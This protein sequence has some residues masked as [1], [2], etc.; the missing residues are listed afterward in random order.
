VAERVAEDRDVARGSEVEAARELCLRQLHKRAHTEG[1]LTLVLRRKGFA[2]DVTSSALRRLIDVGLVDDARLARDWVE[3]HGAAKSRW[4]L[5]RE[6]IRKGV[7]VRL[8]R[9]V[10]DGTPEPDGIERAVV[11]RRWPSLRLLAPDV[12]VRR[13][14]GLLARRGFDPGLAPSVVEELRAEAAETAGGG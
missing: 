1:E 8:I 14:A 5:E 4:M 3:R 9:D 6:L 7:D 13:A 11:A 2:E 12:Q 10:L